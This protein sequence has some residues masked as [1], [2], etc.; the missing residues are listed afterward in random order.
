MSFSSYCRSKFIDDPFI[1]IPV[2][3]SRFFVTRASTSTRQRHPRTERLIGKRIGNP[4]YQM[5]APAWIRGILADEYGV[6]VD[7]VQYL[8]GGEEEPGRR[9]KSRSTAAE[10]QLE[11]IGP[12]ETLSQMLID[13]KID[14]L[15]TARK[16]SCYGQ[17]PHVKRLFEDYVPVEQAY[18]A[19]TKI[20][21]IMH[22]AGTPAR[23]VREESLARNG[24]L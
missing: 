24:A 1:A 15:Y 3:P 11:P 23:R 9:K 13:G 8:T 6:P 18:Y 19:K 21:P 7:S 5:T 2:W 16:P 14:A 10:H 12:T 17:V 20:F 4:E 22:N